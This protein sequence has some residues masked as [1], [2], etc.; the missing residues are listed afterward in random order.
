M[1]SL[2]FKDKEWRSPG[3]GCPGRLWS[4]LLCR[5]SR[6]AWT[7][8]CAACCRWPC[9]GRRVGLGDPQRC[10]PTP[11]I[12]W[13]CDS[14]KSDVFVFHSPLQDIYSF[15]PSTS[16]TL[17]NFS[18]TYSSPP[19]SILSHDSCL[20]SMFFSSWKPEKNSFF[21]SV[22]PPG[23]L[24]CLFPHPLKILFGWVPGHQRS[25]SP[26]FFC[27]GVAFQ[28]IASSWVWWQHLGL[29]VLQFQQLL[30][31]FFKVTVL[32]SC[33]ILFVHWGS[34]TWCAY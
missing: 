21:F 14:V 26:S 9:F 28:F 1:E 24:H 3:P 29:R 5:Y 13:F 23:L 16:S 22:Q 18:A 34:Q 33:T 7:R 6:P 27:F 2:V 31:I 19:E 11:T 12:L 32:C 25:I 8:S 15:P 4:L 20:S 10:L 30:V 17:L